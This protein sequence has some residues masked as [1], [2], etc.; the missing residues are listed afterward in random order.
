[1]QKIHRH[2]GCGSRICLECEGRSKQFTCERTFCE[3]VMQS[4]TII[5]L[6]NQGITNS[7]ANNK[8]THRQRTQTKNNKDMT[9][10]AEPCAQFQKHNSKKRVIEKASH[11]LCHLVSIGRKGDQLCTANCLTLKLY[12]NETNPGG[13]RLRPHPG[14]WPSKQ[15]QCS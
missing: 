2:V 4:L 14:P 3:A 1:M 10:L 7:A 15:A 12:Q 8:Q 6:K 11:C 13:Q 5:I 9:L